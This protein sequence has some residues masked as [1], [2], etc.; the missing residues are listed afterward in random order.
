MLALLKLSGLLPLTKL[1]SLT[2]GLKPFLAL[3]RASSLR[4][5]SL[6]LSA[7]IAT[8]VCPVSVPFE[9]L[10]SPHRSCLFSSTIP[11]TGSQSFKSLRNLAFLCPS[12]P[13]P[14]P[15]EYSLSLIF[16]WQ[17]GHMCINSFVLCSFVYLEPSRGAISEYIP[18]RHLPNKGIPPLL[19][20]VSVL[21]GPS[22]LATPPTAF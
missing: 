17:L 9:L 13:V 20:E 4:S 1:I 12:H 11:F 6:S 10:P 21:P 22:M 16:H 7:M 14:I 8:C 2:Q 19:T 5:P 15:L 18:H 3:P